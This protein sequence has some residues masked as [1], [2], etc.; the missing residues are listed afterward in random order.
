M[1]A[2]VNPEDLR[3]QPGEGKEDDEFEELGG[4]RQLVEEQVEV[5]EPKA[6][7]VH[8]GA[9]VVAL[10][11]ERKDEAPEADDDEGL[12]GGR[13][14][15]EVRGQVVAEGRADSAGG[16]RLDDAERRE[17]VPAGGGGGVQG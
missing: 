16:G 2:A 7:P 11:I 13:E 1:V 4:D 9:P 17:R 5:G 14:R 8:S 3:Q 15:E 10:L 6:Q 12:N